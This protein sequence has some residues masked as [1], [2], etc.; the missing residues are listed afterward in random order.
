MKILIAVDGS[1]Y[2]RKAVKHVIKHYDWFGHPPELHLLHVK[3]PLPPGRAHSILGDETVNSYYREE[4]EAALATAEKLLR[5]EAIPFKSGFRVGSI[6]DEI[7][8]YAKKNK[9]DM[10]VMGSH[11]HNALQN[12]VMGSVATKVLAV[13]QVPVLIVR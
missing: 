13:T 5:K 10:I 2:T 4:S 8:Q 12:L 9:I 3:L 11:G 7:Q 1:V 6:A